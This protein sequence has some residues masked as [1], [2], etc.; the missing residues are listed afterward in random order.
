MHFAKNACALSRHGQVKAVKD[1]GH[2]HNPHCESKLAL[3]GKNVILFRL[4]SVLV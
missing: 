3:I 4:I 2:A 1:T